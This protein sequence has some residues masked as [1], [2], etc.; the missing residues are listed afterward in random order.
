VKKT[1]GAINLDLEMSQFNS[2]AQPL[3]IILDHRGNQLTD[4]PYATDYSIENFLDFMDEGIAN[5][6][7]N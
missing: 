3:Y 6:N 2:N 7:K 1:I 5:F 4:K